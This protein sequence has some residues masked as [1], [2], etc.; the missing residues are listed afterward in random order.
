MR[1]THSKRN[2][3]IQIGA[4]NKQKLL[5]AFLTNEPT[6]GHKNEKKNKTNS[7]KSNAKINEGTYR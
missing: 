3:I 6:H 4:G 5:L 1:K 2:K 7:C